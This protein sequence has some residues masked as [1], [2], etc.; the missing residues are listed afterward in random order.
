VSKVT[1]E[2]N[3]GKFGWMT[4]PLFITIILSVTAAANGYASPAAFILPPADG[5]QSGDYCQTA[6]SGCEITAAGS[7]GIGSGSTVTGNSG[8][9][10][11]DLDVPVV[12]GAL[13]NTTSEPISYVLIGAGLLGLGS[14][15]R[16]RRGPSE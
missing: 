3:T 12:A 1:H 8:P 15:A 13:P 11:G 16:R 14:F 6:D 4:R 9:A 5:L 10:D 2:Q 7:I